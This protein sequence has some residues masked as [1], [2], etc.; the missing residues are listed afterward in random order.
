MF[1]T[2]S[3]FTKYLPWVCLVL[4][5][6]LYIYPVK[7]LFCQCN[8]FIL[9]LYWYVCAYYNSVCIDMFL[10]LITVSVL[11]CLWML[12]NIIV[13]YNHSWYSVI[14]LPCAWVVLPLRHFYICVCTNLVVNVIYMESCHA[15]LLYM[16]CYAIVA[17]LV[18][19]HPQKWM[20]ISLFELL[21]TCIET[22][23]FVPSLSICHIFISII[24]VLF[25]F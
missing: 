25:C 7:D 2:F 19:M 21:V 14:Y 4:G 9:W 3:H 17:I 11:L 23:I 18:D 6:L 15:Y 12:H 1:D 24:K 22:H 20:N 10:Y 16:I 5:I 8:W 13:G